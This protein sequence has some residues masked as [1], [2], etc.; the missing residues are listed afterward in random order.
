MFENFNG[1]PLQAIRNLTMQRAEFFGSGPYV[2][3]ARDVCGIKGN[4][5]EGSEYRMAADYARAQDSARY[6]E[7]LA[8]SAARI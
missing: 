2:E 7:E 6:Q 5:H 3:F 4:D 1:T 8:S